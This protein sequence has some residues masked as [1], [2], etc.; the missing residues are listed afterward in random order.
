MMASCVFG[1]PPLFCGKRKDLGCGITQFFFPWR[2]Y[3]DGS[4]LEPRYKKEATKNK[5]IGL[6]DDILLS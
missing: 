2:L 6:E 1:N 5:Q 3:L 4:F